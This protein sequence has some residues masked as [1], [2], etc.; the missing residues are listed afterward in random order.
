VSAVQ[1]F[2]KIPV[3]SIF[4]VHDDLDIPL[5]SNKIQHG[6]GPRVH[7]GLSSVEEHLGSERFWNVRIGVENR[8]IRGNKGIPGVE[9]SLQKFSPAERSIITTVIE[10]TVAELIRMVS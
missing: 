4:I 5:G 3:D 2:Y 8:E 7:N 1:R 6:K 9:Y 10:N